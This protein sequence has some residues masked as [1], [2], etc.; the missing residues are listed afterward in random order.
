MGTDVAK[1]Y[2]LLNGKPVIDR[3]IE[4]FNSHPAVKEIVIVVP[5]HDVLAESVRLKP[6]FDKV[7]GVT[8][9]GKERINSV[10]NG[11]KE[12]SL[13]SGIILVHDAVRPF[14][15]HS[16]IDAVVSEL[17]EC[18]ACT[19]AVPVK[20]TIKIVEDGKTISSTPDRKKL[21]HTLTPQGFSRGVLDRLFK[22]AAD[23]NIN[24]TDECMVAEAMGLKVNVV[25]GSY[26]NIKITTKEDLLFAD[27]IVKSG[28]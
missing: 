16:D 13:Q 8:S 12:L 2:L 4:V 21:W 18:D 26:N 5:S 19:V 28:Y 22:Y 3:T 14:V 23:N 25:T 27:A 15:R 7:K 1:Q 11:F 10:E 9:G 17:S 20:D 24:G 6:L